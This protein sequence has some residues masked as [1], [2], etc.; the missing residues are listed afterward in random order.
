MTRHLIRGT[1]SW[2][3]Q[4]S[5]GG[6][7]FEGNPEMSPSHSVNNNCHNNYSLLLHLLLL[8]LLFDFDFFFFFSS[9][10]FTSLWSLSSCPYNNYSVSWTFLEHLAH[11][12]QGTLW[13]ETLSDHAKVKLASETLL[14]STEVPFEESLCSWVII[15]IIRRRQQQHHQKPE[16]TMIPPTLAP[17]PPLPQLL[18]LLL[19]SSATTTRTTTTTRAV[20]GNFW[21]PWSMVLK[22][23][24]RRRSTLSSSNFRRR[25]R[26]STN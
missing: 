10:S 11:H 9:S 7:C 17:L 16:K 4:P 23:N 5:E 19:L 25:S 13:K 2:F 8:L 3:Q 6:P 22:P 24:D 1:N 18:L 21:E 14:L 15:I 20:V 12:I 26:C